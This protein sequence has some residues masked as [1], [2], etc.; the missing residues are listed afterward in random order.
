MGEDR[1]KVNPKKIKPEET[2]SDTISIVKDKL[3]IL[4]RHIKAEKPEETA[5]LMNEMKSVIDK[6]DEIKKTTTEEFESYE[7]VNNMLFNLAG[8]GLAAERF[9][10]EFARL[11]SGA[12][13]SLDR[14][15]KLITTKDA[16]VV[17]EISAIRSALEALRNDI[18]LLGPMFYVKKVASEKELNIYNVIKNTIS[19]QEHIIEKENIKINILGDPFKI[20]MREGSCMQI[21]NNLIDNSILVNTEI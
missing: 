10:H 5:S 13:K 15:L 21:F 6:V 19:L 16:R 8:T 17:K 9:T 2:I 12:N 20:T 7:K 3:D 11:V 14:L 1:E 18:K 4:S